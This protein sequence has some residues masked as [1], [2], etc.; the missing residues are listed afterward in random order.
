MTRTK[1]S[2]PKPPKVRAVQ[3][4]RMSTPQQP[5]SLTQ[6]AIALDAYAQSQGYEIIRTYED[7]ALS[8]VGAKNRPAFRELLA[9]VLGGK[10]DFEAILVYDVSR[11]GRFQDPDEAAH[12][13]F[14]C[15]QE[16]VRIVYCAEV[17]GQ[18][19]GAPDALMKAL[20]RAMAAEF[21]R[22]LGAKVR[23]AQ[24]RYASQGYWLHGEPGFGL[25]R[26]V[27]HADGRLGSRLARGERNGDRDLRTI[28]TPGPPEEV[29]VV[30][31]MFALCAKDGLT[32]GAIARALNQEGVPSPSGATWS[33][34]RVR[35]ILTN[36]KYMGDLSTQRRTTPL[37]G[38][39]RTTPQ[40]AWIT[41]KGA[42]PSLISREAFGAAQVALH[43]TPPPDEA[44]LLEA[45]GAIAA[46]HGM[47]SEARLKAMG[48]PYYRSYRAR[49]GSL[50]AAFALLGHTAPKHFPKRS[51]SQDDLL[52]GLA[53]LFLRSGDLTPRLI[54]A[55]PDLPSADYYRKRF[56]GLAAAYA[57]VG[58]VRITPAQ[59]RSPVGKSRLAAR[60]RQIEAWA[61]GKLQH[62]DPAAEHSD[63]R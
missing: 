6:Q 53:R 7:G 57:Y 60:R 11:W 12:Y 9:T 62:A 19:A 22:E 30:Q 33:G 31:R 55:D 23:T 52:Q 39:R 25:A 10:A 15:A 59:A 29:E 4:L 44:A 18:G 26:Q 17:F 35:D 50:R 8:G 38:R 36:P 13:E 27:I 24:R 37:G 2:S 58:F 14:L 40:D 46:T 5:N 47:V 51:L 56:G 32:A 3:Y 41:V 54:D 21:S 1:A 28:V 48:V 49:F 43:V 45:L 20:K 16:G 34:E 61:A 42:G 63:V